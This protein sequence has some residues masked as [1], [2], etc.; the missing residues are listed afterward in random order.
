MGL[1]L[2]IYLIASQVLDVAMTAVA[3]SAGAVELNPAMAPA[4]STATGLV[5]YAAFKVYGAAYLALLA[6]RYRAVK[7]LAW[8]IAAL[9]SV[10]LGINAGQLPSILGW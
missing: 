5:A 7:T 4:V 8:T 9:Y 2:T 10:V 6:D 1:A 3:V